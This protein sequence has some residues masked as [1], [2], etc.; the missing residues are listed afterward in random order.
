MWARGVTV[1]TFLLPAALALA[2]LSPVS[3]VVFQGGVA[4]GY[5]ELQTNGMI[6][7]NPASLIHEG[8]N[9]AEW[10][11]ISGKDSEFPLTNNIPANVSN[12]TFGVSDFGFISFTGSTN[13]LFHNG[14]N[15]MFGDRVVG[16]I[17]PGVFEVD[18][19]G[20][21]MPKD[22]SIVVTD[23]LFEYDAAGSIMPKDS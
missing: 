9:G 23:D 5:T 1:L 13:N 17:D 19:F 11:P 18:F 20:G 4:P 6:R 14:T 10:A 22:S 16:T 7:W 3:N 2:Q 15:L 8:W 21:L 12:T